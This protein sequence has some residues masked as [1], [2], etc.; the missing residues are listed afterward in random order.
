MRLRHFGA[1][2]AGFWAQELIVRARKSQPRE[3][4]FCYLS[5]HS[6]LSF[7]ITKAGVTYNISKLRAHP[8]FLKNN[9]HAA[10]IM[11]AKRTSGVLKTPQ[12][13][14]PHA[15]VLLQHVLVVITTCQSPTVFFAARKKIKSNKPQGGQL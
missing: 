2:L 3:N 10:R 6:F 11:H 9:E 12:L 14:L 8:S 15:Q 4:K 5:S 7:P 13:V 1:R